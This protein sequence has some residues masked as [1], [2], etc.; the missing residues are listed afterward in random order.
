MKEKSVNVAAQ[1]TK[2][3]PAMIA[4][5][6]TTALGPPAETRTGKEVRTIVRFRSADL[7]TTQCRLDVEFLFS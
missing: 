6:G 2:L 5:T 7:R 1:T 3:I 4:S